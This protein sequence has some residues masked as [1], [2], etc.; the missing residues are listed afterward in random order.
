M[1]FEIEIDNKIFEDIKLK[2]IDQGM[3][4]D[5]SNCD[6]IQELFFVDDRFGE[7]F[8]A[9]ENVLVKEVM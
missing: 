4:D 1:K 7:V 6:V 8:D 5:C 3:D 9:R 2:M